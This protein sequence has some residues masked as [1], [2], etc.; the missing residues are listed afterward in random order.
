MNYNTTQAID[1]ISGLGYGA[2]VTVEAI[3]EGYETPEIDY[4]GLREWVGVIEDANQ[5][6][7]YEALQRRRKALRGQPHRVVGRGR[8]YGGFEYDFV[9]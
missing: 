2:L 7:I 9:E 1:L 8:L 3:L 6:K 4:H 5:D